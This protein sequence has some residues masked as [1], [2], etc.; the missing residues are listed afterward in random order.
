MLEKTAP[1]KKNRYRIWLKQSRYDLDAAQNSYENGHYE[2]ACYQSIQ[3]VEKALKAV[4]VHSGFRAPRTHKLGVL[5]SMANKANSLFKDVKLKAF[6]KIES[7]TFISRYPFVV[8]GVDQTPHDTI[9]KNDAQ[10]CLGIANDISE[11]IESFI[12]T[13]K[14]NGNQI[15]FEEYYYTDEEISARKDDVRS[16]LIECTDLDVQK[17]YVFGSF[18]DKHRSHPKNSTMDILIVAETEMT[19][20][21]RIEYVRE[22]TKG[23]FPIIEPLVYK[24]SEFDTLLNEEG[25]GFLESALDTSELLYEK[26]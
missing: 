8:P 18:A 4:V 17:I 7:Y 13:N 25:E 22:K 11:K 15:E 6:R 21:E 9:T 20:I 12:A 26:E 24:P 23:G 16:C 5:I 14:S 10:A 1:G 3:S 2:W 19:F